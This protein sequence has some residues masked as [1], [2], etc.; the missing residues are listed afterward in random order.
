MTATQ[1]IFKAILANETVLARCKA[2]YDLLDLKRMYQLND[3]EARELHY[4]VHNTE[5][6]SNGLYR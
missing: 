6:D 2:K 3:D 5:K 1:N 4:Y